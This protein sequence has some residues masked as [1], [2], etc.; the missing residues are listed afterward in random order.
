MASDD[1]TVSLERREFMQ[2]VAWAGCLALG[3]ANLLMACSDNAASGG[4]G[5]T[6]S[7]DGDCGNGARVVYINQTHPHTVIE[8]TAQEI[9]A[10]VEQGYILLQPTTAAPHS[11]AVIIEAADFVTLEALGTVTIVSELFGAHRHTVEITC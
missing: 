3:G 6:G 5:G 1:R 2:H 8:L 10:A 7:A 11:H 9:T 4:S